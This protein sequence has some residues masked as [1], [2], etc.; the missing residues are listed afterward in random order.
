MTEQDDNICVKTTDKFGSD[1][2][3]ADKQGRWCLP[4]IRKQLSI[5]Q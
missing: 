1:I 4:M 2:L 3:N 5:S